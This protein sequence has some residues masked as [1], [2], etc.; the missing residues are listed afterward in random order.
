[1]FVKFDY[2]WNV[3]L[4]GIALNGDTFMSQFVWAF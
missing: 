1:M 2:E 3:A 4:G